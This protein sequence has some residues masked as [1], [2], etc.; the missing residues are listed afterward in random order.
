MRHPSIVLFFLLMVGVTVAIVQG[1]YSVEPYSP[2]SGPS[3]MLGADSTISFFELPLWIQ[4]VWFLGVL[5]AMA[6]AIKFGPLVLGKVRAVLHNKNRMVIL[7]YIGCNPG[8]TLAD[9]L[10]NTDMNR[11]TARYHLCLLLIQQKVIRK[12]NGKLSY[13]FTNGGIQLNRK[14]VYGYIMNPSKREIMDTILGTPGISN[15]ELAERLEVTQSTISWHLQ[16][17]LDEEM[18]V[19]RWDGRYLNYFVSPK[20]EDILN[21]YRK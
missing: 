3:D 5:G 6:G 17:L 16:P 14:Q 9:L 12:K 13:L 2:Q 19:T 18:V 4:I 8:C 21:E 20:T 7:E 15:K 10:K 11:G 1:G